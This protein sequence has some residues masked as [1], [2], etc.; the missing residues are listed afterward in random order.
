MKLPLNRVNAKSNENE[1]FQVIARLVF[2]GTLQAKLNFFFNV[3]KND[4]QVLVAY[5][6]EI[7]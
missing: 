2:H 6:K 7:R 3:K 5:Y 1:G 4:V